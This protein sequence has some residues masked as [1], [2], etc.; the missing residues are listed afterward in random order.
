LSL[1]TTIGKDIKFE[2]ILE[3]FDAVFLATGDMQDNPI[4]WLSL[5][6]KND[7]LKADT[8]TFQTKIAKVFAGGD[9]IRKRRLAVRSAGDGKEAALAIQ[10]YLTSQPIKIAEKNFATKMGILPPEK[11]AD[12]VATVSNTKK[13]AP[14]NV[15]KGYTKADA[16]KE[17][18]RCLHCD[19]RKKDVCKLRKLGTQFN[20]S[21]NAYKGKT[22]PFEIHNNHPDII[23]EPAKCIDCGICIKIAENN[24]ES[25]GLS[26]IGR[27]FDVKVAVPFNEELKKGLAKCAL[28]CVEKC[29]TAALAK[30]NNDE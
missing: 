13:A 15:D 24:S 25:L 3:D 16:V 9:V 22:R 1:N 12:F 6:K 28:E 7:R 14:V 8:K 30:K 23:Y 10:K 21:P 18:E 20:A 2:K 29:P 27:G 17:S 26:F 19:C 11:L 4:P 5:E